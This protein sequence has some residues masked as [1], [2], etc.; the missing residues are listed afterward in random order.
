M[1]G[2]SSAARESSTTSSTSGSSC[3][4]PERGAMARPKWKPSERKQARN[5][6][7]PFFSKEV[8][9][10]RQGYESGG[11]AGDERQPVATRLLWRTWQGS[12]GRR[13]GGGRRSRLPQAG[14]G[15]GE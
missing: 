7:F 15:R 10:D 1:S 2:G 8:G 5:G 9:H 12:A 11:A 6:S 13:G 4:A 3:P 14:P